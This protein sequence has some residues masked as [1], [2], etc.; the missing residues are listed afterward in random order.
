ME[1]NGVDKETIETY[2]GR[3]DVKCIT[4]TPE[5]ANERKEYRNGCDKKGGQAI[6]TSKAVRTDG[7]PDPDP[8]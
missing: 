2:S 7:L 4:R 5:L 3:G 8:R 6:I 1:H